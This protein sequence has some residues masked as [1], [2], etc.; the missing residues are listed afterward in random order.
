MLKGHLP[1]VIYHHVYKYTTIIVKASVSCAEDMQ[2]EG[3]GCGGQGGNED[4][5]P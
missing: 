5:T 2:V 1:R 3:L 4:P